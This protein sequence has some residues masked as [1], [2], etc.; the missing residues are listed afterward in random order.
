VVKLASFNPSERD[1]C[2]SLIRI[3]VPNTVPFDAIGNE[4]G[5]YGAHTLLGIFF[6]GYDE[7]L[8]ID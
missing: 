8:T 7:I 1:G 2:A 3:R 5:L 4:K 6:G